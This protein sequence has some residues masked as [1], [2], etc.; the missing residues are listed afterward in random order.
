MKFKMSRIIYTISHRRD[1]FEHEDEGDFGNP[2]CNSSVG[3]LHGQQTDTQVSLRVQQIKVIHHFFPL[4]SLSTATAN[5]ICYIQ[6]TTSHFCFANMSSYLLSLSEM[7][8]MLCRCS[9]FIYLGVEHFME[10][11]PPDKLASL[12]L[13]GTFTLI[14]PSVIVVF[15]KECKDNAFTASIS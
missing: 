7:E 6:H 15:I 2:A 4:G 8:Q 13:S 10:N 14:F 3:G 5:C 12:N 11:I 1:Q 9:G